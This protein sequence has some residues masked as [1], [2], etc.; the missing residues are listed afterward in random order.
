MKK[1]HANK[2]DYLQEMNKSFERYKLPELD[3]E[4]KT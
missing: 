2:F 3:Q 4:Q 1:I